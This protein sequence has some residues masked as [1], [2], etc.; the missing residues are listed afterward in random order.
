MKLL[1]LFV[2]GSDDER[3]FNCIYEG[4][5]IKIIKYRKEEKKLINAKIRA[6]KKS[7]PEYDYLFF[8]DADGYTLE[9]RIDHTVK[10]YRD[11]EADKVCVVQFEIESW[12]LAGINQGTSKKMNIKYF[13]CTDSITKEKFNTIVPPKQSRIDFMVE[14]LKQYDSQEAQCKNTSFKL[15][16]EQRL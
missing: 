2:E 6:I 16:F 14:I 3:F 15:F 10:K 7:Y 13:H 12:Y 9:D 5:N 8:T 4:K 1:Y 11:C